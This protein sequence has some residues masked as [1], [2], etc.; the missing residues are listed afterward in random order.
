MISVIIPAYNEATRLSPTLAEIEQFCATP[1][2]KI[3]SEVVVVDDGS[4]DATVERALY[5]LDRLPLCIRRL[6]V[7]E[8]KWAAVQEGLRAVRNDMILLLD[9]DGSASIEEL[10]RVRGLKRIVREGKIAVF[11]SR[12]CEGASVQGKS[13]IR[14]FV[15]RGY[16]HIAACAYRWATGKDDV[17]DFQ[18]P[19]KLFSR[20]QLQYDLGIATRFAGDLELACALRV[21]IR[22]HPLQF[23]HRKGSKV[24]VS[25][26]WSML[27]ETFEVAKAHRMFDRAF[28]RLSEIPISFIKED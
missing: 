8:G 22:N 3:V 9:A 27:L 15:S 17:D 23:M 20:M 26:V 13:I 7:N 21:P 18:A 1:F 19:F 16:R 28:Q 4:V 6:S 24:K 11:G 10:R 25:A 2:G 5:Y 12:F 14:T